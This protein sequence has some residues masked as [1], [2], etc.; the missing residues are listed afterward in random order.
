[1]S[2]TVRQELLEIQSLLFK[3]KEADL[4]QYK[5]RTE[6][7][8]YKHRRVTGVC[9]Y[10]VLLEKS[11]YDNG[12]RL[13]VKV[14]RS[15][16]HIQKD[17]FQSG[18]LV[19]L[20]C[21]DTHKGKGGGEQMHHIDGVVNQV[22][23]QDMFITLNCDDLPL[24]IHD[25]VLGVQL[26]F[27]EN[28]YKEMEYAM[29]QVINGEN[30]RLNELTEII[31]GDREASF[32]SKEIELNSH[33]NEQQNKALQNVLQAKDVAI[34]HGPPGTG[35]TTTVIECIRQTLSVENQVLVCAPSNA[36]VDLLVLKLNEIGIPAIRIGHP[37]RVTEL[38]LS[39]T[40]DK[41]I[42]EHKD[43]K[44]LRQL[45]KQAEEYFVLSGKW[46]RNFGREERA[47][48]TLLL[49]EARKLKKEAGLLSNYI[50]SN[51]IESSQVVC[52]TL[53]GASNM[54]LKGMTFSS[55]F[56][57]EA[58][59]ALEPATWI[60]ILKS[61]KVFFAGDHQ[62][63]PP[64]VKSFDAGNAGLKKTLFEKAIARN[65]VDVMLNE[66]YRMHDQIMNF[67]SR[68]FYEGSLVS[69]EKVA[70]WKV[71]SE[72]MPMEFIDTAGTGFVETLDED[73]RS[74]FNKEE[75]AVLI[76]HLKEYMLGLD[77]S[78]KNQLTIGI[79]TPY[80]AQVACLHQYIEDADLSDEIKLAIKINTVDSFQGQ[81][82]DVIY[83]SLVRSNEKG[84][85][86]FLSDKRRMNVAMT[87]AKKKLVI[88]GDSA[89][90][91]RN[92]FYSELFDYV[93]E[94][95]AYRSAFELLYD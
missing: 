59:Q 12:E 65:C 72:D 78:I 79:I 85:I 36:A 71:H 17:S 68:Q 5:K 84:E 48:R 11:K 46:K 83:I 55:V 75:G 80:R 47:Q 77:E 18:K 38:A 82:R 32:N 53:V 61:E 58:A 22:K 91:C 66:Q 6:E 89:T 4:V 67:S 43:Y 26:L 23:D 28:A 60:P 76:K 27:D 45:K 19:S 25:G 94:I 29:R 42:T 8:S 9:W 90:I 10:P 33:L 50:C 49:A 1:M 95:G 35:K 69:N 81:E 56:I 44:T 70:Q 62:Q 88:V 41:K 93:N 51:I 40:L 15:R 92:K 13:I 86:G 14:S 2:D 24:W 64:T 37:A 39:F 3:E 31:L 34:I 87:R 63:L 21:L 16:E 57:D 7:T 52:S 74:T 54:K 30:K 20:F 73:S